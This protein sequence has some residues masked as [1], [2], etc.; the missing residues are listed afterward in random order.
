M[1]IWILIIAALVAVFYFN[2]LPQWLEKAKA[3]SLKAKDVAQKK[4]DDLKNK[5]TKK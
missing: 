3:E 4:I 5:N 1:F 2:D